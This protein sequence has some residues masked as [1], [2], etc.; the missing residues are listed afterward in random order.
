MA[1]ERDIAILTDQIAQTMNRA[2]ITLDH[3]ADSLSDGNFDRVM[4]YRL[5]EA[6]AFQYEGA[7]RVRQAEMEG[8]PEFEN[9]AFRSAQTQADELSS[10]LRRA[11]GQLGEFRDDLGHTAALLQGAMRDVDTLEQFPEYD[12][13]AASVLRNRLQH[14]HGLTVNADEGLRF[15]GDRLE[16]ARQ[17]ADQFWQQDRPQGY[18]QARV[19]IEQTGEAVYQDVR[20]SRRG[21]AEVREDIDA[22]MYDVHAST[23]YGFDEARRAAETEHA[24]RVGLNPTKPSEQAGDRGA[25]QQTPSTGVQDPRLRLMRGAPETTQER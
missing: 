1:N 23:Q 2:R 5:Q 19:A 9:Y 12:K 24:M 3:V 13:E 4:S 11:Q 18:G 7:N 14:L 16:S 20:G 8:D 21:L 22:S 10:D 6:E 17:A 25:D 15:A